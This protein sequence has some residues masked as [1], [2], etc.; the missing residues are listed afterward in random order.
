MVVL[1]AMM[2]DRRSMDRPTGEGLA[3]TLASCGWEV[4]NADFRGHGLSS[5]AG[6]WTY[7][8]LV[9]WDVPAL[10]Q[11][12]R[13]LELG[14]VW[15]CGLS[16]G[17]HVATAAVAES[18]LA[19]APIADGVLALSSNVWCRWAEPGALQRRLKEAGMRGLMGVTRARG[20]F[21]A[22]RLGIG[23]SNE[24]EPYVADLVRFWDTDAW[25]A[26]DGVNWT[27]ALTMC[28]VP[29]EAVV[30]RGDRLLARPLAVARFY[31]SAPRHRVHVVGRGQFGLTWDPDHMGLG[32]DPRCRA[33]WDWL[34]DLPATPPD[35]A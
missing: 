22:R 23:P 24:A 13:D 15:V 10:C 2:V 32:S 34:A 25:A 31:A 7:D 9:R 30:G 4:L 1:H 35:A 17:G 21:P 14:P 12:A 20:H 28:S 3:S 6:P 16:L 5:N 11:A 8:D 27:Q 29:I 26:R 19:G 33:V 18:C